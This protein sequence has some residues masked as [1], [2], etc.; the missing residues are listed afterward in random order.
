M[1]TILFTLLA[2]AGSFTAQ[3]QVG[4]TL[5]QCISAWGQ[6]VASTESDI[7]YLGKLYSYDFSYDGR[8]IMVII[9]HGR[10]TMESSAQ[11]N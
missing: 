11:F 6:P 9:Q 3:A 7:Q 5:N 1:K 10:V 4:W 8:F 2:F